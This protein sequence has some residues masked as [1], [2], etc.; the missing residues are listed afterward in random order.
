[1]NFI[2]FQAGT[3]AAHSFWTIV[4]IRFIPGLSNALSPDVQNHLVSGG[5][6]FGTMVCMTI[7][8]REIRLLVQVCKV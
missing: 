4:K 1:M 8:V 7:L 2:D 6:G 5:V 3:I